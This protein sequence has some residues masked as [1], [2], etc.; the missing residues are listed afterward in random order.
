MTSSPDVRMLLDEAPTCVATTG[1]IEGPYWFD[2]DSIRTDLRE[3]RPGARL[4]LALRVRD[5]SCAVLANS[6]VEIWQCD[7]G[8]KYS[9]F[10]SEPDH[11]PQHWASVE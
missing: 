7:A 11:G 4:D 10:E 1:A 3:D 2:V 9:G 5:A 6:V 8:G